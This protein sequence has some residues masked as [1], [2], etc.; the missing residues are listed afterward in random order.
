MAHI[1][2]IHYIKIQF[3]FVNARCHYHY[4][5]SACVRSLPVTGLR[6]GGKVDSYNQRCSG[7]DR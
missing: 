5:Q 2:P 4:V 7:H 3:L 1:C 6:H